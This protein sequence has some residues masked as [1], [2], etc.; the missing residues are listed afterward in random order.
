VSS[1][2]DPRPVAL[3]TGGARGIGRAIVE[4]LAADGWAVAF[5][6][7]SDEAAAAAAAR[8]TGARAFP[9]DLRDRAR[10]AALV[11]EVERELG[12]IEGLVNNA[13]LRREA[14]LAMTSDADW[15]EVVDVN[16]GGAFR[17]CRAVLPGMV[18]RRRGAIVNVSSRSAMAGLPG[19]SAYAASKAGLLGMTRA[20]A[21]EV[22]R[23]GVRVNVVVPGFVATELTAALPP[24]AVARLR[25]TE[26]LPAGTTPRDVAGLVAFL[27]SER[28][29]AITGQVF[30]VDAGASA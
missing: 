5:T 23:K 13:G 16:L 6:W 26:C 10:P 11:A 21:R 3:V 4:A 7:I 9:L 27:L 30:P 15:D 24:S 2:A 25:D 18:Y 12:P 29:A 8:E 17:C 14:I 19:Q 20:L 1:A 22:G 28:A